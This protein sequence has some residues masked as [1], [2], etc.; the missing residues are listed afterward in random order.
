MSKQ[1]VDFQR[2]FATRL[3][4]IAEKECKRSRPAEIPLR[5]RLVLFPPRHP[6]RSRNPSNA[7]IERYEVLFG[8]SVEKVRQAQND[9][10]GVRRDT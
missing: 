6:E 10:Y 5:L 3:R 2:F 4:V 7:R 8:I 9:T 1:K